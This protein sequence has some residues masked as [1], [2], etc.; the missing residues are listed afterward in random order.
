MQGMLVGIKCSEMNECDLL[1]LS[2]TVTELKVGWKVAK[3]K[4]ELFSFDN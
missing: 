4:N 3:E 2:Q 1:S